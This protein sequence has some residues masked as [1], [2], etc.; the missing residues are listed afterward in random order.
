MRL[1]AGKKPSGINLSRAYGDV[2]TGPRRHRDAPWRE[3][4][5]RAGSFAV[6]V[7]SLVAQ[8]RY[9]GRQLALLANQLCE[10]SIAVVVDRRLRLLDRFDERSPVPEIVGAKM[11]RGVE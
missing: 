5:T 1:H 6:E 11:L 8:I 9:H 7:T 10:F 2:R 4:D 3:H